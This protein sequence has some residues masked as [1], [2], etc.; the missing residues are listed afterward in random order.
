MNS[1]SEYIWVYE[2]VG[3]L[4]P[5]PLSRSNAGAGRSGVVAP[6]FPFG[7]AAA[8]LLFLALDTASVLAKGTGPAWFDLA[9]SGILVISV[10]FGGRIIAQTARRRTGGLAARRSFHPA[11]W[12][13]KARRQRD[14]TPLVSTHWLSFPLLLRSGLFPE[15]GNLLETI[16]AKPAGVG[17][18]SQR[19]ILTGER[20][21][22]SL[23]C[24]IQ[25]YLMV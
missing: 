24:R 4:S 21:R 17:A 5:T 15:L 6:G 1:F 8:V 9:G 10:L 11:T 19:F 7:H 16:S 20:S 18:A 14:R 2:T 25:N 22:R 12:E 3:N 13:K 23:L